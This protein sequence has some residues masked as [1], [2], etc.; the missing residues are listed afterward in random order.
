LAVGLLKDVQQ[1]ELYWCAVE[2][3]TPL[4]A[5]A[6][7]TPDAQGTICAFIRVYLR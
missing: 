3:Q 1:L 5:S 2:Q 4:F 6:T 7:G